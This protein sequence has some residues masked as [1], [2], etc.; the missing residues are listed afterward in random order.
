MMATQK[1][2]W[3]EMSLVKS[4]VPYQP[5]NM[6]V[7]PFAL[8]IFSILIVSTI[9]C[10]TWQPNDDALVPVTVISICIYT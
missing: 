5:L 9:L 10:Q 2:N 7:L 6:S 8:K 3:S 4:G 1:Q